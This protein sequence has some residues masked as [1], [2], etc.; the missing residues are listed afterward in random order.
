MQRH[1]SRHQSAS[2]LW[3]FDKT[4][5]IW[6]SIQKLTFP[7]HVQYRLRSWAGGTHD[8]QATT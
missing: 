6:Y 2:D 7:N 1:H 5:Q 4:T 8:R 3:I